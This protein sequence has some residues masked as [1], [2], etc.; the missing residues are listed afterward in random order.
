MITFKQVFGPIKR[1]DGTLSVRIRITYDRKVGYLKTPYS[2]KPELLNN[3][4]PLKKL[5]EQRE[6]HKVQVQ[7]LLYYNNC[8]FT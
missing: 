3:V 5:D 4:K 1:K 8:I 2:V 6:L 7:L